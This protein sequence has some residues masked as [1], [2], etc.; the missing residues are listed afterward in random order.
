[1]SETE[2]NYSGEDI[3]FAVVNSLIDN[4]GLIR[5]NVIDPDW[6][7]N[8]SL[9]LLVKFLNEHNG[10]FTGFMPLRRQF[11]DDY[12]GQVSDQL[13]VDLGNSEQLKF[14]F[15]GFLASV[16]HSYLVRS[17]QD[18]S[19]RYMQAPTTKLMDQ[20]KLIISQL[21]KPA[22]IPTETTADLQKQ[23]EY[24]LTH[25]QQ[26]GIRT[27]SF[28]DSIG[29]RGLMGGQL[30]TIGARPSVG[31]SALCTNIVSQALQKDSSLCVDFFSLEMPNKDNY[32][33]LLSNLTGIPNHIIKSPYEALGP[34]QEQS[35]KFA[36]D[37]VTKWNLNFYDNFMTIQAIA[38]KIE[39]Q[40]AKTPTGKYLAIIDY[41]QL[42]T[43]PK[44][45]RDHRL[46]IE[47]ITRQL[48]LLTNQFN[49]PII[50][51]SQLSRS[52][53]N[54]ANKP[55]VLSDLR[56]SGSIEQDSNAV[57]FLYRKEHEIHAEEDLV[58]DVQKN[59]E[60]NLQ[61]AFIHFKKNVQQMSQTEPN[62]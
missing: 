23:K 60:G 12:P 38:H 18:V 50:M 11:N 57:A 52:D 4:P 15:S 59:R 56:E 39:E 31:K 21:D 37:M 51:L 58:F 16:K 35:L 3:E 20:M 40:A 17:L 27:F 54:N 25:E 26:S 47:S 7:V 42:V 41:L 14:Q 22:E 30:L 5:V 49:I 1:M 8:K 34:A 24:E 55:P 53:K 44:Q 46:E 28:I 6:F 32:D 61:K 13:W 19:E 48:K 9:G 45:S 10:D 43:N 33:R 29:G 62:Y 2:S 36:M